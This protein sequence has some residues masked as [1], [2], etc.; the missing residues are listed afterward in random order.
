MSNQMCLFDLCPDIE[1]LITNELAV[2][3]KFREATAEFKLRMLLNSKSLKKKIRPPERC[4]WTRKMKYSPVGPN[5]LKCLFPFVG[6]HQ[7]YSWDVRDDKY[8]SNPNIHG[9][10]YRSNTREMYGSKWIVDHKRGGVEMTVENI[11]KTLTELGAKK[12]KSKKKDDKIKL[13]MNY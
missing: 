10:I 5:I 13:L 7:D 9:Y 3:L 12:F 2:L 1:E 6:E 8:V 11:N 4:H